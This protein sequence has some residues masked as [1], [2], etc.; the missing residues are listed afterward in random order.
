VT[1]PRQSPIVELLTELVRGGAADETLASLTEQE[2]WALA[3]AW[4]LWRRPN[5]AIPP[6]V[7]MG[8]KQGMTAGK[9]WPL[10]GRTRP[11]KPWRVGAF[12]GSR[13]TGKTTPIARYVHRMAMSLQWPRILLVA[14]GEKEMIK[15]FVDA[16]N[17]LIKGAPPWERPYFTAAAGGKGSRLVWPSGAEAVITCCGAKYERGTEYN[18]AWCTELVDWSHG[19]RVET[20]AH[21]QLIARQPPGQILVDSTPK[22]GHPIL[23][24]IKAKAETNERW[25]WVRHHKRDNELFLVPGYIDELSEALAGTAMH[26]EE[27]EG[28]ESDQRG[29]VKMADI[30]AARRA[31]ASQLKRQI[32]VLDPTGADPTKAPKIDTVGLMR[33]GLCLDDQL[34]PLEDRTARKDPE[35]YAAEAVVMYIAGKC[36]CLVIETDRGGVLPSR[37]VAAAA[38]DI[39]PSPGEDPARTEQLRELRQALN[40]TVWRV[41]VVS[42]EFQ[43]RYQHGVIYV[44]EVRT[45]ADRQTRA[46]LLGQLYHQHRVSHPYEV[47]LD[48]YETTITTHEF[49][50]REQSPGDLDCGTWAAVELTG[51]YQ[52]LKMGSG[53]GQ[54]KAVQEARARNKPDRAPVRQLRPHGGRTRQRWKASEL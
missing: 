25:W 1:E 15:I 54:R 23:E 36:D 49:K 44:R 12:I 28:V 35:D 42:V 3:A 52:D 19:R 6:I 39:A 32:V 33:W 50:P 29:L 31:R 40:G 46:S 22:A 51:A 37:L 21:V 2:L 27:V 11:G 45:W 53:A 17:G 47:D 9:P 24:E 34:M 13:G 48:T 5:Q 18:G 10:W 14:Q 16:E 38:R 43:T 7:E 4:E 41:E 26:A 30:E 8:E 20:W